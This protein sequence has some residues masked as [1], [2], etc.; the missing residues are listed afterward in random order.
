MALLII[1]VQQGLFEQPTPI[2]K[3]GALLKNIG[4]LVD[5]AHR[6]GVPVFYGQHSDKRSLVKGSDEWQLHSRT[7]VAGPPERSTLRLPSARPSGPAF[8][9]LPSPAGAYVRSRTPD[10]RRKHSVWRGRKT[11]THIPSRYTI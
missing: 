10:F 1:D 2:Y 8:H 9:L 3:A 7:F 5:H 11:L 6:A 4:S